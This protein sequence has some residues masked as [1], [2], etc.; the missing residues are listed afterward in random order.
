LT[1]KLTLSGTASADNNTQFSVPVTGFGFSAIQPSVRELDY[2]SQALTQS[3]LPQ[4]LSFTNQS[5]H[6]VQILGAAS[7]LNTP[8]DTG[9]NTLPLPLQNNSPVA[10][11]QV[12]SND[13]FPVV[14]DGSTI[15]YRCDSDPN[16]LNS[17]FRISS[18]SCTGILLQPQATCSVEIAYIPQPATDANAGLD[19]FLE[20]NTV[21]CSNGTTS[22][23]EID[24]GRFPVEL[25][26]NP[27]SPLRM[28]PGAGLDFGTQPLGAVT[29]PLTITLFNDPSDPSSATVNFVGKF[30]MKGDYSETDDCPVSLA[31]GAS[32]TVNIA[33]KPGIVGFDLGTLTIN[34]TPEPTGSPQIM[35]LRGTGR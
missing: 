10:G 13:I 34:Y 35:Y 26:A 7:C 30:V 24:G 18:D 20:L 25:R 4:A 2:G 8:P 9:F 21:Q 6:P 32:C 15:D 1:A 23:C 22:N 31:P 5:P 11:L 27:P 28:S 3:S 33:F 19:Y 29:N 14:P 12:I 17:N 16:T